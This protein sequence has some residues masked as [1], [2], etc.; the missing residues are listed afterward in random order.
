M[1]SVERLRA[2]HAIAAHGSI[3]AAAAVLH[4]TD[5]AVSQQIARLEREVGHALLER[6]GRGVRLTAPAEL[7]VRRAEEVLQVMA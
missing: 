4:V 6:N 5:S 3:H 7:L 2:L 1:L